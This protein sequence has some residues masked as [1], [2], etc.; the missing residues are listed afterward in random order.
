MREKLPVDEYGRIIDTMPI[1]KGRTGQ[2]KPN[3]TKRADGRVRRSSGRPTGR[4]K[5]EGAE[6]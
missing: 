5:K 3:W 6:K 1:P 2:W 4:P